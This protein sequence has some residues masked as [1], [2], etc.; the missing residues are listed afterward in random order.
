MSD[1]FKPGTAVEY[2]GHTLEWL[3]GKRG[4]V[5][6]RVRNGW[7]LVDFGAGHGD[8]KCAEAN[9]TVIGG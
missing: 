1:Q 6:R 3:R 2:H 9:L 7:L 4:E 5:I 8:V